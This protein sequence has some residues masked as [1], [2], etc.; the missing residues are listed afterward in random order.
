MKNTVSHRQS[1]SNVTGAFTLIELLVVIAIIAILAAILFPVFARARENARKSSCQ[2]NLKQLGL[3]YKMYAGESRGAHFP[4]LQYT[5][6]GFN[7]DLL[8]FDVDAVYPEYL[9][10]AFGREAAAFIDRHKQ[11]PFLLYLAFNAVHTPMRAK[12]ELIAKYKPGP[13][14][15]QGNPTYA[16]MLESLDEAVGRVVKKLDELKLADRTVVIFTS[17]NGGLATLEGQGTPATINAPLREGKGFLYEGGVRVPLIVKWPG[18][19]RAGTTTAVPACSI[20]ASLW[21]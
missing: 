10:D 13:A 18:V 14:G 6:P 11:E 5:L 3:V 15:K 19:V 20:D 9:T 1:T 21:T 2:S 12:A 16:A 8:G 4:D 7:H 17:D